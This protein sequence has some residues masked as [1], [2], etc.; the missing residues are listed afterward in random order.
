MHDVNTAVHEFVHSSARALVKIDQ[1]ILGGGR[2]SIWTE[3]EMTFFFLVMGFKSP[4]RRKKEKLLPV[5]G[6]KC[7]LPVFRLN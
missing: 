3:A 6:T 7:L 1:I 4:K 5:G 2:T